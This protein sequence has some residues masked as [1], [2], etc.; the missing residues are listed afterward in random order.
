MNKLETVLVAQFKENNNNNKK[1]FKQ[2]TRSKKEHS[3]V[4][5]PS[6]CVVCLRL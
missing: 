5:V 3:H 1:L 6:V 4:F 2:N